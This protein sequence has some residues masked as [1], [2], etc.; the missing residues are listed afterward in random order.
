MDELGRRLR[1]AGEQVKSAARQAAR[2]AKREAR[3]GGG[4]RNVAFAGNVGADGKLRGVSVTQRSRMRADG[5]TE[6]ETTRTVYGD[7]PR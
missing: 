6:V 5:T 3:R 1:E 7:D 4:A 2:E